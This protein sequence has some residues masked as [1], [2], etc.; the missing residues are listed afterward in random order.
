MSKTYENLVEIMSAYVCNCVCSGQY[1]NFV[2]IGTARGPTTGPT[3]G[4][5]K[6]AFSE[7]RS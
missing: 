5:G 6:F 1:R 7:C 2:L 3:R 4:T